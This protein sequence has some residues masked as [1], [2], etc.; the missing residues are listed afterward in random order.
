MANGTTARSDLNRAKFAGFDFD[1]H[2]D[3]LR[4]R[5]QIKFAADYNDFALAS[6]GMMLLDIVAFGLDSL[7][8]YLDRRATE[9]YLS[10]ARTRRGV[11]RLSRQLGY[12]MGGAVASSVDLSIFITTP[13]AF[14]VTIS[15][16][17]QFRGPN[18][19]IFE[20]SRD[21]VWTPAEQTAGTVKL[22]PVSEGET[23]TETF[24]SDGTANQVFELARVPE[25]KFVTAGTVQVDVDGAD[26][27]ETDFLEF[28]TTDQFEVGFNDDP[29]TLRFGDGSAGNI[30]ATAA[31][32][33]ATYLATSGKAGNVAAGTVTEEI[34]PLVISGD[35]IGLSIS[36]PR[37]TGGGDD[38]ETLDHAKAFA[39]KVF[40]SRR[41]AVTANDY[42]ALAGSF[43]DPVFGRVA[44]AQAISS[45]SAADDLVLQSLLGTI[46]AALTSNV[47]LIRSEISTHYDDEDAA[48]TNTTTFEKLTTEL[49]DGGTLKPILDAIG[50]STSAIDTSMDAAITGVRGDRNLTLD[51]RA[52]A[53]EVQNVLNTFTVGGTNQIVALT[54]LYLSGLL[55][56]IIATGSTLEADADT[57]VAQLGT[58]KDEI[59]KIG[60]S[61]TAIQNDGSDSFLKDANDSR[62]LCYSLVGVFDTVTPSAST[63]L[64]RSYGFVFQSVA[65]AL[66]PDLS[67]NDGTTVVTAINGILAHVDKILSDECKAN[68][69][70]VPILVR[71]AAGFYT[72]PSNG[73]IDVLSD[74]LEERKEVTQTVEVVSGG[75]FLVFPNITIRI[76]V[77]KGFSLDQTSASVSTAV[78]GILRDRAFGKDLFVSDIMKVVEAVEGVAFAN[79]MIDG[80]TTILAPT[81]STDLLDST[82]NLVIGDGA[83]ITKDSGS[84]TAAVVTV[85]AE[86]FLPTA[87]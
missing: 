19:L 76:G 4:A 57:R 80:S 52:E 78:D 51:F 68:L 44:V 62:V 72:E 9:A 35:N 82:G 25:G 39:G 74:F 38:P 46:S 36:H 65:D 31:T 79:V 54:S 49:S 27:E 11:S 70:T 37:K 30:P 55:T 7:S 64:A 53:Q 29:A 81:I 1:T 22:V 83:V 67:N 77:F 10:T 63:G 12:K 75:N 23:F 69:V 6:L 42:R 40:N 5:I 15:V 8:F 50:T 87:A 14:N 17:F 43:A 33:T 60:T 85:A 24:T 58:V 47:A 86:V 32:V 26:W 20:A 2:V 3:D 73:L 45:R 34:I 84:A 13:K 48:T 71:D 41:V 66:D 16:G 28:L 18:N 59:D 56:S 21:V 61:V